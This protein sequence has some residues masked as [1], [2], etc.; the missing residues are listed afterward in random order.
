[1]NKNEGGTVAFICAVV[2][3]FL[4]WKAVEGYLANPAPWGS[5]GI[6]VLAIAALFVLWWLFGEA[7]A[8]GLELVAKAKTRLEE[9]AAARNRVLTLAWVLFAAAVGLVIVM[10]LAVGSR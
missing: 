2:T 9:E 3:V 5:A 10:L 7:K 4:G 8:T 6:S 1:M